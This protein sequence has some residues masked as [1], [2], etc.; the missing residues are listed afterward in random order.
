MTTTSFFKS[1]LVALTLLFFISCDKDFNEIGSEIIGDDHFGLEKYTDATV[2]AYNQKLG[3]VQTNNL[4]L[5]ALG[6]YNSPVFGKTTANFLTQVE[7]IA[8]NPVF[9]PNP[10]I[11]NVE[12]IV[13]YFS[14]KTA[15]DE[16]GDSEYKLD[17]VYGNGNIKLSVYRSNYY[18]RDYDPATGFL[19]GQKYYSDFDIAG[20][21]DAQRL[22]AG[23]PSENDDFFF[24]RGELTDGV[25]DDMTRS[26]PGMKM[27]L[28]N[29]AF[30]S[31]LFGPE[32]TGQLTN[33]NAFKNYFRGLYFKVEGPSGASTTGSLAMLNFKQGKITVS[34]KVDKVVNGT[35]VLDEQGNVTRED[36]ILVLTLTGNTVN[37]FENEEAEP[38][39]AN[40][41]INANSALGDEKLYLKGGAG[42]IAI[43][44]LFGDTDVDE[45][46]VPDELD[47]LRNSGWLVNEANLTFNIEGSM[48]NAI[49]PNRIYL[50]DLNNK[51]PL[52]DYYMDGSVNQLVKYNKIV[53]GGIIDALPDGRGIKYKIRI[54]NHIRALVKE[55]DS[56]NVRLGLAVTE[57][58]GI[59]TSAKLKTPVSIPSSRLP[60]APSFSFDRVPTS[61]V[62][63]PLGTVL[64]G[65][66]VSV[67]DASRLKLEIY[68]T[69]PD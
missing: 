13:P 29:D 24:S 21:Y 28:R 3:A 2:T 48:A 23:G 33:N 38:Y 27:R 31:T 9:A 68:F 55:R 66:K 7:L 69:K 8:A 12:M 64:F 36:K 51:R 46:G 20:N 14:K 43:I 61:S 26:A 1:A 40:T 49:E 59:V 19:E 30:Q 65:S 42:S 58:I 34:Y 18:L 35:P 54:T 62:I 4:P 5:N 63:N 41:T 53:H 17:S 52:V 22:N 10:V 39:L 50:Y 44:D 60:G 32:A 57:A 56:T 16:E 37:I 6:Y 47:Q 45:N 25:G 15:T 11:T 67:P